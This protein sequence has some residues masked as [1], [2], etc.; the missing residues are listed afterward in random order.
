MPVDRESKLALLRVYDDTGGLAPPLLPPGLLKEVRAIV[1]ERQERSRLLALGI[2][3]TS[4]AILVGPP[5]VGKTLSARWIASLLGQP[6]WVL[7]LT[8]VM[9]SLL[10]KTGNNLRAALDYA[11]AN[12]AVLLLDE[13]DAIAKRRSDESDVGEL[14]RLVTVILQ[15]VDHWPDTGLLLAATNHPE[16]IDPA[17]WRRF[18]AVLKFDQ[19]DRSATAAAIERFLGG[20][21]DTFRRWLDVL[22][23]ALQG[24]SLSDVERALSRMRRGHALGT[25]S[26]EELVRSLVENNPVVHGKAERL[27]LALELARTGAYPHMEISKL[28]GVARDTI[29]K[30]AGPSP[31]QGRGLK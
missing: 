30:Y 20:D 10:G 14:K 31:R 16:L 17:L 3:P 19:P 6:L 26:V 8:A 1:Q 9:S 2:P 11:K 5:G 25:E 18:D 4:S 22:S 29:R 15:E 28:T 21:A 27:A 13:I 7:D 24:Q 12:A 23:L